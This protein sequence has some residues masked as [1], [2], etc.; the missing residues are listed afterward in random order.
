L[1]H[2]LPRNGRNEALQ[3][4]YEELKTVP[5]IR[6]NPYYWLQY[7]IARLS[8][9]ELG[10]ARSYFEQAYSLA[11]KIKGFDTFQIDNHYC[12]LLLLEAEN[13]ADTDVAFRNVNEAL[14]TLKR[15]VLRENRHYPYRASWNLEGV[16]KRHSDGW[17]Q[18]QR[19]VVSD[20]ASYL[21]DAVRHLD[22]HV[23]Q[24]VAVVGGV[25]RLRRVIDLLS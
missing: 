9:G 22:K 11:K 19:K 5:S 23:A 25:E 2:A 3:N 16:V 21:I 24:S 14:A 17:S 12:R 8:F 4:F 1:D 18:A 10:V 15:K 7:S 6:S 20:G 13:T